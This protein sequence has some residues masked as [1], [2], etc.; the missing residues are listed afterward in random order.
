MLH[1]RRAL[2]IVVL[3]FCG[4]LLLAFP[5]W[6]IVLVERERERE[7]D[8]ILFCISSFFSQERLFCFVFPPFFHRRVYFVLYFLHFEREIILFCISSPF[9]H[10]RVHVVLYFLLV[11]RDFFTDVGLTLIL[12][13]ESQV[14]QFL[15][16][17]CFVFLSVVFFF[18]YLVVRRLGGFGS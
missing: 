12:L 11:E 3:L 14:V 16:C 15:F 7:R 5:L 6:F 4:P 2:S 8:M 10:R 13:R 1:W 17:L 9:F 18:G